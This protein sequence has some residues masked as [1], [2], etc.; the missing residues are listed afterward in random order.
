[1]HFP[2]LPLVCLG[3]GSIAPEHPLRHRSHVL[4]WAHEGH[5]NI[6]PLRMLRAAQ[7]VKTQPPNAPASLL[8]AQDR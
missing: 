4:P 8:R 3:A 7:P 6:P 5:R 1:M 2:G